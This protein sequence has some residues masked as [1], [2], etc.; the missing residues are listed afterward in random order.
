MALRIL[1]IS[2]LIVTTLSRSIH[3]L[4]TAVPSFRGERDLSP[5]F[6]VVWEVFE[7]EKSIAFTVRVKTVGWIEFGISDPNAK[8]RS[9]GILGGVK[10]GEPYFDDYHFS[11]D[12]TPLKDQSQDW[13]LT[14]A[15]EKDGITTLSFWR[16]FNTRDD[17]ED[18]IIKCTVA[19]KGLRIRAY[20]V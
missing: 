3:K 15:N 2:F 6:N 16:K 13:T 11:F 10:D 8:N 1:T 20:S 12:T 5:E 17:R 9:D 14:D 7:E 19:I 4:S 18:V